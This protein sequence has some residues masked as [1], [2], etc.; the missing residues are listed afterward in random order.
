M[1]AAVAGRALF[2]GGGLVGN[3]IGG[4]LSGAGSAI[5]GIA[6]G[7]G[8][9]IQGVGSA[10]GG[11]LQGA[12]TPAPKTIIN[13]IG[14]AGTAGKKKVSG[15]GTLPAPKKAAK[16]N[17]NAN[18]PTEKLLVVAVNY[19][20]S[21]EKTLQAQLKFEGLAYQQ[22]AQ[23]EREAAV[24]SGAK[25][26]GIFSR[27]GEKFGA[28]DSNSTV[29]SRASLLTKALIGGLGLAGL[30]TLGISQLDTAEL[31]RLKNN[32]E[33][34]K[35]KFGW[36]GDIAS[37]IAGAGTGIGYL[38]GGWRG[39][40]IGAVGDWLLTKLTG[41]SIGDIILGA[42]GLGEGSPTDAAA[43][44]GE[45]TGGAGDTL[46]TAGMVGYGAYRGVKTTRDIRA[47]RGRIQAR[48]NAPRYELSTNRYRDPT[49]G[50]FVNRATAQE[51]RAAAG[52]RNTPGWLS[53]PKGQRFV[54]FLSR[55][56]GQN[57]IAK[58]ILPL[59]GRVF[60]G[61]AVT[62][63]GIGAIPGILW[64]LLN[65]GLGLYTVY[66]LLDAWWDF[67]D[68]EEA[69]ED[70]EAVNSDAPQRQD[71][72]QTRGTSISGAPVVSPQ[73]TDALPPAASGPI[74][75][76]LDKNPEQL[77]DAEL[78]QLVEAQGRI[79]DPRGV[80][81]NP[82][83]IL[84]GT[85]PLKEH[86]IGS[87]GANANS[88]VKIA[89]YDTPENGIRAAMEN[90][91]NSRYYRGKSVRE[92]LGTWSGGNGAHY[93]RMLGSARPGYEGTSNPQAGSASG[94]I[95]S[96]MSIGA[97]AVKA[98]GNVM[99]AGF[100]EGRGTRQLSASLS[101]TTPTN[102]ASNMSALSASVQN[103]IDFGAERDTPAVPGINEIMNASN[104][105]LK[106]SNPS[107]ALGVIDPNYPGTGGVNGYLQYYR[108]AA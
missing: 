58:K 20:S 89:V 62:A 107:G 85:G 83:G 39:A 31:D 2:L 99:A 60:A 74:D 65:I 59:L 102:N 32:W 42:L 7:A 51:A 64:T 105:S 80:T 71:A 63:T 86:Q 35:E 73:D 24:E 1:V 66:E 61:L 4:A 75:A 72:Q 77:T 46:M 78:R 13:N 91:R 87:V 101:Q 17:V 15:K 33:A 54:A 100:G 29:K 16:P 27:L 96:A 95:G 5:G 10:V 12:L 9:A 56:F 92:G 48:L 38:I 43:A 55:R 106:Q 50:R 37:T 23:A 84:Y 94:L 70:A 104:R 6:E 44:G 19:L 93:A 57:Y 25:G 108:L 76:I 69:R 8:R 81:N 3:I 34:F 67:Q 47:R 49:T 21:I 28:L 52:M 41:S 88:S 40:V 98:I 45:M 97:G 18:M 14:I 82:G 26:P 79:E 36:L 103:N 68:E 90:W 53:G 30:A 22:Q 11:A